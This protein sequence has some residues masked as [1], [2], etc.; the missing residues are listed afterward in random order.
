MA[1]MV[2]GEKQAALYVR[3][4]RDLPQLIADHQFLIEF[5]LEPQGHRHSEGTKTE[6]RES[7]IRLE[8]TFELQE[9]FIVEGDMIDTLKA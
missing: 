4:R 9:R 8:Q 6:R 5:L 2:L 7:Y 3:A 1:L